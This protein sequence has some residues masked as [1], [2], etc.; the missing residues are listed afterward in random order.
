MRK[1]E[2]SLH[3][4]E[5][6]SETSGINSLTNLLSG[7]FSVAGLIGRAAE[8]DKVSAVGLS[9]RVPK[10]VVNVGGDL[11]V[12]LTDGGSVT[13]LEVVD[14][15]VGSSDGGRVDGLDVGPKVL[16][17]MDGLA[18][19]LNVGLNDGVNVGLDDVGAFVTIRQ[20][21]T[22]SQASFHS[23]LSFNKLSRS[24]SKSSCVQ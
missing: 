19:G 16:A 21:S 18:D 12:G 9:L 11:L 17:L 8:T 20:S 4:N 1:D 5:Y 10:L 14:L 7:A 22:T 23:I 15:L 13:G 3:E 6:K 2:I 24:G